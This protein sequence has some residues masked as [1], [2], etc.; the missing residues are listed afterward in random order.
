MVEDQRFIKEFLLEPGQILAFDNA[1]I[2]HGRNAI[3]SFV[4]R[5]VIGAY[6]KGETTRSRWRMLL[7]KQ[8]GM[9]EAWLTGCSDRVL[10]M[11]ADREA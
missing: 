10:Q 6:V 11:L 2:L 3:G 7:G 1:R 5:L 8:S 4:K 9:S